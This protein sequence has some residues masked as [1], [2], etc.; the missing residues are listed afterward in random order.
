[1]KRFLSL[2]ALALTA[3]TPDLQGI[4]DVVD[5]DTIRFGSTTVRLAGIDAPEIRQTCDDHGRE[6][7]CGLAAKLHLWQLTREHVWCKNQQLDKYNR[8][9]ATCYY[10]QGAIAAASINASMVMD[11][12]AVNYDRYTD[13]Y[14]P[15]QKIAMAN[16]T[17]IWRGTFQEPEA[18]R[19]ENKRF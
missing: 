12:Y 15:V 8:Y 9:L 16:Q 11:G 10:R 13:D 6:W 19:R 17:G 5:G 3:C 4:P 18:W 1:M 7:P 14:V 2:A